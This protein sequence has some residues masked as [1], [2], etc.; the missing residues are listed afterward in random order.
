MSDSGAIDEDEAGAAKSVGLVH[1]RTSGCEVGD[2]GGDIVY[3]ECRSDREDRDD[4]N[5]A[6]W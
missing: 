5:V 1:R 6:C 2:D 3:L 4:L